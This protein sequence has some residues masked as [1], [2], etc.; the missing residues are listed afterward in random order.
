MRKPIKRTIYNNYDLWDQYHADAEAYL[1]EEKENPSEDEIWDEIYELDRQNWEEAKDQMV[2]FFEH[3]F[4]NYLKNDSIYAIIKQE[5]NI[6][7]MK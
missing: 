7:C 2:E 6:V 1:K 4:I 5:R 3:S